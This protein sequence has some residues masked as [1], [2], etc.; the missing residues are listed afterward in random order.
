MAEESISNSVCCGIVT[1]N[2]DIDRLL[3][4]IEAVCSQVSEII[5]YD[6]GSINIGEIKLIVT[7]MPE[8]T[9]LQSDHNDGMSKA[10][11]RLCNHALKGGSRKKEG[12]KHILL[13][14]QDSVSYPDMVEN[15]V[16]YVDR[17]I[18]IVAP[19]S[20]NRNIPFS[21]YETKRSDLQEAL[22]VNTS[23]SLVNLSAFSEVGGYNE[24][25]FVDWVDIEYCLRL[26][27]KGFKIA[28]S[29]SAFLLHDLGESVF[30]CKIPWISNGRLVSR[31]LMRTNHALHRQYDCARSWAI[32][33]KEHT[34]SPLIKWEK[35]NIAMGIV[36]RIFTEPHKLKLLHT[37]YRGYK[38]GKNACRSAEQCS[39]I[40]DS[41]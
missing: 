34:G 8:I 25:L 10:L 37:L 11:N 3:E 13:L 26:R 32:M 36:Q 35:L 5:I 39:T 17:A 15:L 19:V 14:D 20:H 27:E 33:L 4:N 23:G 16:K 30:I 22:R 31:S 12:Y 40:I 6:N 28:V 21:T 24:N 7:A 38:D 18:G 41:N 1:Y 2:P 9:L 29:A